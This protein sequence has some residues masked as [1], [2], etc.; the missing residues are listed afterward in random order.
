MKLFAVAVGALII[1]MALFLLMDSMISRES[2]RTLETVDAQPIEFVRTQL[3]EETRTKDRRSPPPPKP[4][5]IQ[6]PKADVENIAQRASAFPFQ[7]AAFEISSMLTEGAGI[8]IGQS[9]LDSGVS[10]LGIMMADDLIPLSMLPPQYPP[11]ARSRNIEGWVDMLFTVGI[12][13]VVSETRV[14]DSEPL[15]TFDRAAEDAA[16]RWRFRPVVENGEPVE[17]IRLIR[18]NFTLESQ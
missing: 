11:S 15:L 8:A 17:A 9:L 7:P 5:E 18:I 6:R 12:D 3:E 13:G 16:R 10:N 4:A 1:N 2:I 14:I